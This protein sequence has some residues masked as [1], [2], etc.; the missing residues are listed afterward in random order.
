MHTSS[1]LGVDLRLLEALVAVADEASVSAAAV[2]LRVAQ[3]SLSRQLR[4]LERRLGLQLFEKSGRR[5]QVAPAAEPVVEAARRALDSADDVVRTAHRAAAGRL[6]RL[7]IAVLP[8]CS[9]VLLVD[10][11]AAFREDHPD[12]DT[13]I[14]ELVDEEQWRALRE[15]RIDVALNLIEPPPSDLPHQVLTAEQVCLVVRDD[16]RLAGKESVQISDLTGETVTFFN[17]SDQPVGYRWLSWMLRSA[18]LRTTLQ[19][20]TLTNIVAA[21]AAGLTVSVMVHSFETILRPPGVQYIPVEGW[22][23]DLIISHRPGPESP[24]VQAFRQALDR[25]VERSD[26]SQP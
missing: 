14:I 22:R 1:D 21:V 3:P 13:N 2:R 17:R 25:A 15:G 24:T 11:L 19:E 23:I 10:A 20:A 7:A 4:L 9:P 18:G 12:V 8:S 6:G 5:L 26:A 16:H